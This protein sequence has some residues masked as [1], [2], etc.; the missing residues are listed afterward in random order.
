MSRACTRYTG[1]RNGH[2]YCVHW[3]DYILLLAEITGWSTLTVWHLLNWSKLL[4]SCVT[5]GWW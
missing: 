4:C 5:C 2:S 3:L 1:I